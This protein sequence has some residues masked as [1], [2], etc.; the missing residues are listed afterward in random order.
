MAR[1]TG[2]QAELLVSLGLVM[3]LATVVQGAVLAVHHERSLRELLGR[4]LIAEA[5]APGAAEGAVV[6]GA[7]WWTLHRDGRVRARNALAGPID[8]STLALAESA[9]TRGEVLLRPGAP[10][11]R[12]RLAAP[13]GQEGGVA[14]VALPREASFRM[15]F[16]ALGVLL[17]VL[18][19]DVAIFSLLGVQLLRGRVVVPLQRLAATAQAISEGAT[20]TRARVEGT[21]EAAA[22]ASAFNDMTDTLE[23]RTDALEKAVSDLRERNH[24]LGQA[25]AGL[26]RAERLAAVGRLA[27]GVAHEVGNPIG[28]ILALVD[29]AA[30]DPGLGEDARAHLERAGREGLRVRS[31]LR[32]LLDFSRPPRPTPGPVDVAATAREAVALV[33]AQRR[34]AG[35]AFEVCADSRAPIALADGSVVLQILINLL[36]NAGDAQKGRDSARVRVDVAP[37]TLARRR[38]DAAGEGDP[39]RRR[40]V[41]DAVECRIADD[42]PGIAPEHRER[43]FDPFFT[44]KP[45]GEGTGLGLANAARLTEDLQGEL[46]LV[47]PP[48]GLTTAFALRL[49]AVGVGARGAR[50]RGAQDASHPEAPEGAQSS[51]KPNG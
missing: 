19:A 16:S 50:A 37:A 5:E 20:G 30:R 25:R 11:E 14:V 44:T 42:G 23:R 28:A 3:V 38:D 10:W 46:L 26:D 1:R 12:I 8:A 13:V 7:E 9:R 24:E 4:A 36:I 27:S 22:L 15:R 40:G 34:Y 41:P 35:V 49:P 48:E 51:S 43:V 6:P 2:I 29:L 47:P 31:I 21:A 17:A 18:L 39:A 32:Q 33:S 45:P